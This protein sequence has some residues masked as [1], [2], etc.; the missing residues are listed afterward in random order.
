MATTTYTV[1][2]SEGVVVK[3][4][5]AKK[6]NAVALADETR[7]ATRK[8]STVATSAGTQVYVAKGVRPMKIVP[9]Y[10]RVVAL[11]EGVEVPEGMRVAYKKA[12]HGV[13]I[14]HD[15]NAEKDEQYRIMNL[16]SND[17]L[18]DAFRTT[19]DAGRFVVDTLPVV[20]KAKAESNA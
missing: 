13:A 14:L 18:D 8:T 19:R 4:G 2:D 17:L 20:A 12:R 15:A 7:D 16:A 9:A 3:S 10:S 5:I 11:P 6:A 1:L